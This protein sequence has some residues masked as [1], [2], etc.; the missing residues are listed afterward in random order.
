VIERLD[1]A[2]LAPEQRGE[3]IATAKA[4]VKGVRAHKPSG[5]DAF[6]SGL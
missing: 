2:Q 6:P 3:A 4:L 5:V 1:Q